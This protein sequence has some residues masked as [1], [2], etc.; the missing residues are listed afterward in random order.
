MAIVPGLSAMWSVRGHAANCPQDGVA[1][2]SYCA[3]IFLLQAALAET[4]APEASSQ[5]LEIARAA[6]ILLL[7]SMLAL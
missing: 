4:G 6:D 7:H 3:A 2:M 1:A 5:A